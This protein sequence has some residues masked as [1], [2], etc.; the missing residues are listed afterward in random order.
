MTSP[1]RFDRKHGKGAFL[2]LRSMLPDAAFAYQQIGSEFGF[3]RQYVAQ[4]AKGLGVDGTRRRRQRER[5]LH[6]EPRVIKVEYPPGV[7]SVIHKIRRSGFQ[8]TPYIFP[9]QPGVPYRT[10]KSLKMV[11]VNGVLCSIQV[12]KGHKLSPNDREYAR[13]DVTNATKRAKVALWA[14]KKGR[15]MRLYVIPLTHLRNVSSVYIPVEGKYAVG[16]SHKPRKDW[17]R[18]ERTWHLLRLTPRQVRRYRSHA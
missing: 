1:A 15:T 13:F 16:N 14:I 2:R 12:R 9:V 6:R 3:T 18:Y 5:V 4:I 7:R 10:W 11:V 8:V 17:T